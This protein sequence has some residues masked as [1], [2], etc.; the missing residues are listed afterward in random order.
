MTRVP[1]WVG[2]ETIHQKEVEG[3]TELCCRHD[4][5]EVAS[6]PAGEVVSLARSAKSSGEISGLA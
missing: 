2:K 1:A 3:E 5:S 6:G 4:A